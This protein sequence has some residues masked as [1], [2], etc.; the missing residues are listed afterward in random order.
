MKHRALFVFSELCAGLVLV[1]M[2]AAFRVC[3][4][5]CLCQDFQK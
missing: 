1:V 3:V 5:S 2:T 4:Q